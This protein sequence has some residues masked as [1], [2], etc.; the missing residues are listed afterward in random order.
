MAMR[1]DLPIPILPGIVTELG[2]VARRNPAGLIASVLATFEAAMS[3]L[4]LVDRKPHEQSC[5]ESHRRE[6]QVK[7]FLVSS[8]CPMEDVRGPTWRPNRT[9]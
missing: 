3:N 8:W 1:P 9:H 4:G 5:C 2:L 6:L 7:N